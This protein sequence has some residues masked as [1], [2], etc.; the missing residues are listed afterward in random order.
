MTSRLR[1]LLASLCLLTVLIAPARAADITITRVN[2]EVSAS[3][4][5]GL[6]AFLSNAVDAIVGL[7]VSFPAEDANRDGTVQAFEDGGLF[8]SYQAEPEIEAQ[9]SAEDG[10]DFR[11]GAF[12]FDGFYLVKYG[13]M[14]Q[15]ISALMLQSV[16]EAQILLS[17]AKVKDTE[18]DALDH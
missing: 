7:K 13:G 2:G 9:I 12:V 18:I 10:F 6:V 14:H 5:N 11:H 1:T 4:F 15:G 3:N 8:I 16:D 17:G